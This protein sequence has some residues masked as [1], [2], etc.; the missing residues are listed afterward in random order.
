M[1]PRKLNFTHPKK[2]ETLTLTFEIAYIVIF[3]HIVIQ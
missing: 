2:T 3:S 1:N